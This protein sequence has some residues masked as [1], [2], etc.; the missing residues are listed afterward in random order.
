MKQLWL[1]LVWCVLFVG[2]VAAQQCANGQCYAP[3]RTVRQ[4]VPQQPSTNYGYQPPDGY[5][6]PSYQAPQA[7][8]RSYQGSCRNGSCQRSGFRLFG[9]RR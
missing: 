6:S 4:Y 1:V 2:E 7:Y 5:Q 3:R 9:W 8:Y